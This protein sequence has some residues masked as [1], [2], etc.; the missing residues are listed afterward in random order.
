MNEIIPILNNNFNSSGFS[1]ETNPAPRQ[2][3]QDFSK[4][5][6]PQL[7]EVGPTT[8]GVDL[9]K[10]TFRT[11]YD[12][13][14]NSSRP[15]IGQLMNPN[16]KAFQLTT[17]VPIS[18]T[19]TL[20]SDGE[21]WMPKYKD[22]IRG[23][24]N[25]ARL[26][27]QQS[28]GEKILNTVNRFRANSLKGAYDVVGG[29]YGLTAGAF[30]GRTDAIY[31]N[32][33][34]HWID[35]Q[36]ERD[37][38]KYKNY[39][40]EAQ[41]NEGFGWNVHSFDKVM[42]GA[43]F[44]AR[45]LVAETIMT[46]IEALAGVGTGGASLA[47]T[48]PAKVARI[49]SRI[50]SL[51]SKAGKAAKAADAVSD[52]SRLARTVDNAMDTA[53]AIQEHGGK[54]SRA[55]RTIME[56]E[57]KAAEMG[58]KLSDDSRRLANIS[59]GSSVINSW[60]DKVNRQANLKNIFDQSRFL[61]VTPA[62]EAGLEA[63]HFEKQARDD[64]NNYYLENYGRLPNSEEVSKF[65]D[66]FSGAANDVFAMNMAILGVSNMALWGDLMGIKNPLSRA[67][68]APTDMF[69]KAVLGIGVKRG[70][71]GL[72]K[73]V[74][75]NI[76][77]KSM[78]VLSPLLKGIAVEGVFEEGGQ[79]I[80]SNTMAN[81][82]KSSYNPKYMKETAS[83]M[84]AAAKAF[85]DQ[86]GTRE[87]REEML[88]GAL[89]GGLFGGTT[90]SIQ[91]F[92]EAKQ[93][94]GIAKIM[95]AGEAFNADFR[96]NP[97]G[98]EWM[99]ALMSHSNRFQGIRENLANEGSSGDVLKSAQAKRETFVSLLQTY[100][101]VG[102]S[103]DF[104][105]MMKATMKGMDVEQLSD[106]LGISVEEAEL[107]K[108][109]SIKELQDVADLYEK[110][111]K[112]GQHV[113]K[114]HVLGGKDIKGSF[115][116]DKGNTV[117]RKLTGTDYA[118]HLAYATVMGDFYQ[119]MAADT[120]SA[121]LNKVG[122]SLSGE[123]IRDNGI[124]LG[125]V[126]SAR[127][128]H[129]DKWRAQS[130]EYEKV[131]REL[132]DVEQQLVEHSEPGDGQD[133]KRADLVQRHTELSKKKEESERHL[134]NLY[135]VMTQ[136]FFAKMEKENYGNVVQLK[137]FLD[138][139]N[140]VEDILDQLPEVDR[141]D[142]ESLLNGFKRSSQ[143][144]QGFA[145]IVD[146][147]QNPNLKIKGNKGFGIGIDI[148]EK[149]VDKQ[150]KFAPK[151][152]KD[153][154]KAIV[155]STSTVSSESYDYL[156]ELKG[157]STSPI[158]QE[159]VDAETAEQ[160]DIDYIKRRIS[161]RNPLTGV[162]LEYYNKFKED[163]EKSM[164]DSPTPEIK[165]EEKQFVNPYLAEL[166]AAKKSLEDFKNGVYTEEE[167]E[168]LNMLEQA[169]SEEIAKFTEI[170]DR[171]RT[172]SD[173]A[174]AK[175]QEEVNKISKDIINTSNK[176]DSLK[177]GIAGN[178]S[179]LGYNSRE[180]GTYYHDIKIS[181]NQNDFG[182]IKTHTESLLNNAGEIIIDDRE[183]DSIYAYKKR[184]GEI[185]QGTLKELSEH[186]SIP[187]NFRTM[188]AK[189][190]ENN[191][192]EV[193]F[194]S[195]P[196]IPLKKMDQEVTFIV[197]DKGAIQGFEIVYTIPGEVSE[198]EGE[199]V[200]EVKRKVYKIRSKGGLSLDK[201]FE[202]D[203]E[204][205]VLLDENGDIIFSENSPF[206]NTREGVVLSMYAPI[207]KQSRKI[208]LDVFT[209]TKVLAE[210]LIM[211][212]RSKEISEVKNK[213]ENI[214]ET[215]GELHKAGKE[216]QSFNASRDFE[217]NIR[218][219]QERQELSARASEEVLAQDV[220]IEQAKLAIDTFLNDTIASKQEDVY[221][222]QEKFNNEEGRNS[223]RERL[224]LLKKK[225]FD[226][227][228]RATQQVIDDTGSRVYD[229]TKKGFVKELK[230]RIVSSGYFE[231]GLQISEE[232]SDLAEN[233]KRY[234]NYWNNLVNREFIT[235]S[236]NGKVNINTN[237]LNESLANISSVS[238]GFSTV[239]A[240]MNDYYS[241]ISEIN[242]LELKLATQNTSYDPEGTIESKVEWI[243][244]NFKELKGLTAQQMNDIEPLSEEDMIEYVNL[245]RLGVDR[246][247]E[248]DARFVELRD[249]I[250]GYNTIVSAF[251]D[252]L[253]SLLDEVAN[254]EEVGSEVIDTTGVVNNLTPETI[255]SLSEI[256]RNN[257]KKSTRALATNIVADITVVSKNR[258]GNM[259]VSN[260]D[261]VT[262]HNK[263]TSIEGLRNV[264]YSKVGDGK[265]SNNPEEVFSGMRNGPSKGIT[266]S[267]KYEFENG[268][269]FVLK[270][271][272]DSRGYYVLGKDIDT[273]MD[274]M[275]WKVDSVKSNYHYSMVLEK[276]SSGEYAPLSGDMM[277]DIEEN[278]ITRYLEV[279]YQNVDNLN[280]GDAIKVVYNPNDG[281]NKNLLRELPEDRH[282][283]M[284][285]KRGRLYL[286]D[287]ND[288]F[289]GILTNIDGITKD[290]SK[291]KSLWA[292]REDAIK[293]GTS[294]KAV[295]GKIFNNFA[296]VSRD[297]SGD[298]I[299]YDISPEQVEGYGYIQNRLLYD[300]EGNPVNVD[301]DMYAE[302]TRQ[303]DSKTPVVYIDYHGRKAV[304]PVTLNSVENGQTK[305]VESDFI[306]AKSIVNL[307]EGQ[308]FSVAKFTIGYKGVSEI[309]ISE[310]S[311]S[312][313]V[314]PS[315]EQ[316]GLAAA[317]ENMC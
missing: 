257:S 275:E 216:L 280:K 219:P 119:D 10:A 221:L 234:I 142:I 207:G 281:F 124:A 194:P 317:E 55:V 215:Y 307:E 214:L 293:R 29:I 279:D 154:L 258:D 263:L 85:D 251:G 290:P 130:T 161:R 170:R 283:D 237:S 229:D 297:E 178:T 242:E 166:N 174:F 138:M 26:S 292:L 25:D 165:I 127:Q 121:F 186:P 208:D 64:F 98:A 19:H 105:D 24:D 179:S 108:Q 184:G 171:Y 157:Y 147:I 270:R 104:V 259:V 172:E 303:D 94:E 34:A 158:T 310:I 302:S 103:A 50:G 134:K 232:D 249:S 196:N 181:D 106:T 112:A 187:K 183:S 141:R 91:N 9:G 12:K 188:F 167:Q 82:V 111:F 75:G 175:H 288:N 61:L 173:E 268:N 195:R 301:I 199:A 291:Y 149:I 248:E 289:L 125:A 177:A 153:F 212:L 44:T 230:D 168:V 222:V 164:Q 18:E 23:V 225:V 128:V 15:S 200:P 278:G 83:L 77:Q 190:L 312:P 224:E 1:M 155:K 30:T 63:R 298:Y 89:I 109:A 99:R 133:K 35:K 80:A 316:E 294:T 28:S 262:V 115:L 74:S 116:D 256:V 266:V 151:E 305:L 6:S 220:H 54:V 81:Y 146:K 314:N 223:D 315:L 299:T 46:G 78:R 217:V 76:A 193:P 59:N 202:L 8:Y 38:F 93:Q 159:K 69:N 137:D 201:A 150:D 47:A 53:G 191:G 144:Y 14:V 252:K 48:I 227:N 264:T 205:N 21:T 209:S 73:A 62:Y 265:M 240:E 286:Y 162:D 96:N 49:G 244:N 277:V 260:L 235:I 274:T 52:A 206:R 123:K 233:Q 3:Q 86:F 276:K 101:S 90:G 246:S 272:G 182:A 95:N 160:S 37:N 226:R 198:E 287:S 269:T 148:V 231:D 204:G 156:S 245:S 51:V 17:V 140:E 107:Y 176:I 102:R 139:T 228:F 72:N 131:S 39:Y 203:S 311:V 27:W 284:L 60:A 163:I 180:D 236:S 145:D 20:L 11:G 88:I 132:A 169:L 100:H 22:Y 126:L 189:H 192:E 36:T 7:P 143:A 79:G 309:S 211:K 45:M 117:E 40:T 218:Y 304:I 271:T 32:T 120:W 255:H 57:I 68:K 113:F 118:S 87:G 42:G 152:V 253:K 197:K 273:F 213:I 250:L 67:F 122:S 31:N 66:K 308:K 243:S 254:G 71:D 285:V 129:Q 70:A 247:S 295:V 4:I 185:I 238:S 239:I 282:V 33:V 2:V 210:L 5:E 43:E 267:V 110:T 306:G 65:A 241:T 296:M 13:F 300:L 261:Y 114:Q 84:T 16:K 136:G 58:V 313:E 97:Y 135:N 92:K 41:R 56:P